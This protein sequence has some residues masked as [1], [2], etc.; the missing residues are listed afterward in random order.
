[1]AP[2][3]PGTQHPEASLLNKSSMLSSNFRC[4]QIH[5]NHCHKVSPTLLCY[6]DVQQT[7]LGRKEKVGAGNSKGGSITVLLTSCLTDLESAV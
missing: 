4:D 2:P 7:H 6:L 1:M 5:K 3:I